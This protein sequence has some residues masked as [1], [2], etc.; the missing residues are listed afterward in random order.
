MWL[1]DSNGWSININ[2]ILFLKWVS[3]IHL[4]FYRDYTMIKHMA[5]CGC[6]LSRVRL[7]GTPWTTAH[8]AHLS[9]KFSR[10]E[11][12]VGLPFP[13]PGNFPNPGIKPLSLMPPALTG[14][15]FTN[16]AIRIRYKWGKL[17]QREVKPLS[18]GHTATKQYRRNLNQ[19]VKLEYTRLN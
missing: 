19:L 1:P 17:K 18:W 15:L 6:V 4:A 12:C 8:Q 7:F 11:F 5:T 9:M 16:C 13:T 2:R 10:P 14:R 3:G